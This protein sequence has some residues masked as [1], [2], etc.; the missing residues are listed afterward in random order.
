MKTADRALIDEIGV[1]AWSKTEA[2]TMTDAVRWFTGESGALPRNI[3]SLAIIIWGPESNTRAVD[4]YQALQSAGARWIRLNPSAQYVAEVSG[5]NAAI[6]TENP[7][8]ARFDNQSKRAILAP[9][10]ANGGPSDA[11]GIAA[12]A[13]ELADRTHRGDW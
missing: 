4:Q 10:P 5:R 7:P 12:A 6:L 2:L 9:A 11:L 8:N 1:I 13:L 3:H